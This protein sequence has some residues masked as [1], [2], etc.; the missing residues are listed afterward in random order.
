M[1]KYILSLIT[2]AFILSI[3]T[4]FAVENTTVKNATAENITIKYPGSWDTATSK[5]DS[6]ILSVADPDSVNL[7]TGLAET[8]VTI[9]TIVKGEYDTTATLYKSNNERLFNNSAYHF[10]SEANTTL[11]DFEYVKEVNYTVDYNDI[12]KKRRTLWVGTP[13]IVYIITCSARQDKFD[14]EI[15]NFNLVLNS[16]NVTNST[17]NTIQ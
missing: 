2:L 10:I 3:S 16:F 7:N 1:K 11:N 8:V 14:N 17:N 4:S 15:E 12:V 13:D 6:T 5:A 9:Q